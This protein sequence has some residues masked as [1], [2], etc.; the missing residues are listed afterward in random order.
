MYLDDEPP[1]MSRK[2]FF[3]LFIAERNNPANPMNEPGRLTGKH[4]VARKLRA[5]AKRRN[6]RV[7][8]N[9]RHRAGRAVF[10]P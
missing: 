10:T 1:L 8:A 5:Q 7:K 2:A 9:K 3:G 6:G 4:C